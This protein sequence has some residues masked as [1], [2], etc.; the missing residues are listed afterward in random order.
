MPSGK[1]ARQQRQQAAAAPPPVRSKGGP[2]GARQASPRTLAIAG[3]V[4]LVVIVAV[5][6]GIVLTQNSSGGT[7][8]GNTD[9]KTILPVTGA[10]A[11]GNSSSATALSQSAFVE[12]TLNGIPQNGL[13]LGK[14]NAPVTLV[15]YIDLQCPVCAAFVTTQVPT[16][17]DKYV[18]PGKLK[19]KMQPWN[20]LDAVHQTVDSLRGQKATIGAG[21]Q[22]KAFNFSDVLYWNQATEGTNWLTDGTV[23]NIAGSVDGM[24]M[25][26]FVKDA[27]SAATAKTIQ[28]IDS[29]AKAHYV[30]NAQFSG[31]PTLF[32]GK[33]TEPPKFYYVGLPNLANLE[34]AIDADLK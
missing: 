18:R 31:T 11:T 10:P 34:A 7:S 28:Q 20:I 3:G 15:E 24:N 5:V 23:S 19:I 16:L 30:P 27:N 17:I 12:Q 29:Y 14:P 6:L 25:D 1:K 8:G 26:Q 4:I 22:N 32:L 13:V 2:G 9:G 21:D 33:G